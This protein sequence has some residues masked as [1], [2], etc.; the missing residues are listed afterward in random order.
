MTHR[1]ADLTIGDISADWTGTSEEERRIIVRILKFEATPR[2]IVEFAK[3]CDRLSDYG[4]WF[5]LGTLW[6]N[7]AGYSDLNL[8]RRLFSSKRPN[9]ETS[10]MKPSELGP[11]RC[12]PQDVMVYRAHRPDETDWLSYTLSPVVAAKMA[13][14][15]PGS[16]IR[17]HWIAREKIIALFLRRAEAEVIVLDKPCIQKDPNDR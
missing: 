14:H 9:R 2:A 7:Y 6:V 15:R 3:K 11:F 4:Y 8:W 12:L 10:L 17:V 5:L 16:E 1:L 13:A